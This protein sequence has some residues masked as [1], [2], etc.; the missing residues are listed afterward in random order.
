LY[1]VC[2]KLPAV[3]TTG[4]VQLIPRRSRDVDLLLGRYYIK[5]DVPTKYFAYVNPPCLFGQVY[6][7][8][9]AI[10][11]LVEVGGIEPPF[12]LV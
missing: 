9:S 2:N 12:K 1:L 7:C 5:R 3:T 4:F 10:S 8:I 6:L 11:L